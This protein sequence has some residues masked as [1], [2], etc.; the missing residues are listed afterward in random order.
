MLSIDSYHEDW[1]GATDEWQ[2]YNSS[3]VIAPQLLPPK[4][5]LEGQQQP[6]NH[7]QIPQF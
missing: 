7:P 6:S 2:G 1:S 3:P 4:N 5:F